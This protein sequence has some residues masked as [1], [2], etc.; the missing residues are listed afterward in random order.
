M[1]EDKRKEESGVADKEWLEKK[2]EDKEEKRIGRK[3]REEWIA[4]KKNRDG[5]SYCKGDGL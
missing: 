2:K 3:E 5:E 4:S 1:D